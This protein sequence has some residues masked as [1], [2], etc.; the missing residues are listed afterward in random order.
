MEVTVL[1]F[2][3]FLIATIG[4]VAWYKSV[5]NV[6]IHRETADLLINR[7]RMIFVDFFK[8]YNYPPDAV[9]LLFVNLLPY[10][11]HL[12]YVVNPSVHLS[13]DMAI[14]QEEIHRIVNEIYKLH[15]PDKSDLP[16]FYTS[17]YTMTD[18]KSILK[19]IYER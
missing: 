2:V 6:T 3:C 19:S 17:Y 11:E 16:G 14:P 10:A 5:H 18:A 8:N 7:G 9:E 15:S 1:Y 12:D 4:L 13:K